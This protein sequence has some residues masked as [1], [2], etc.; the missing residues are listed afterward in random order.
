MAKKEDNNNDNN[1]TAATHAK[2][3]ER[4]KERRRPAAVAKKLAAMRE[5]EGLCV[6]CVLTQ[7]HILIHWKL[8]C[9]VRGCFGS[10]F[11]LSR[12]KERIGR[13]R[14]IGFLDP[15][16]GLMQAKRHSARIGQEM[17]KKGKIKF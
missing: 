4:T 8:L 15:A 11:L 3:R 10:S 6:C 7:G 9:L 5:E 12:A 13:S 2:N 17:S 1:N 14:S 16:G